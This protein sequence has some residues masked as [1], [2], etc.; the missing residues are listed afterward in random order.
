MLAFMKTIN[1]QMAEMKANNDTQL[2]SMKTAIIDGNEKLL[3]TVVE[4]MKLAIKDMSLT[5]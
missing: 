3:A 4:D 1:K 2:V 5:K